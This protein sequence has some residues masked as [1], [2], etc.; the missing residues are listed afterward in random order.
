M[1]QIADGETESAHGPFYTVEVDGTEVRFDH[2]PVTALDIMRATNIPVEQGMVE[3][4]D[5]GTQ[6]KVDNA[7]SFELD[8]GR[9]LKKRPRF[10]RGAR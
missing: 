6:R 8:P 4:L 3:V 9:R 1:T 2:T 5:D 7:E 10:R